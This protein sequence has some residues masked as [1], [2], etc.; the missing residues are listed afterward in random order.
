MKTKIFILVMAA[1]LSLSSFASDK[2]ANDDQLL[3]ESCQALK[4][5][6]EKEVARACKY[7]IK[8]FLAG[9]ILT[10]GNENDTLTRV[11][12]TPWA[13]FEKRAYRTRVGNSGGRTSTTQFCIPQDETPS[14]IIERVSQQSLFSFNTTKGLAARINS[15][16]NIEYPCT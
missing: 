10:S 12:D 6:P 3:L 15:A 4:I 5:N 16:L 9:G 8:G 13:S 14:R 7:Y 2:V 1:L 11:G